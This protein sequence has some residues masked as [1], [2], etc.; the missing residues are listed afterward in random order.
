MADDDERHD[1]GAA[2]GHWV[3]AHEGGDELA[4][5]L[6]SLARD[7]EDEGDLDSTLNA[8][9]HAAVGTIPGA[10]HASISMVRGRRHLT[11]RAATSAT[12]ERVDAIQ[13]ETGEGPCLATLFEKRTERVVDTTDEPR[14]PRFGFRADEAGV[15]SLLAVQLYVKGD[16]LGA[17]NLMSGEPDA[18]DDDSEH[19]A[20]LLA[21][22]AAI[23]IVGAEKEDQLRDALSRRDV[24]G[25]AMGIIMERYGMTSERA[26]SVLARLSQNSNRKLHE[27]AAQIVQTRDLP[28]QAGTR[29]D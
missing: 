2:P 1:R 11:T 18:F 27:L 24:I 20:L 28:T 15:R 17:L 25:Q 3:H 21:T 13:Y 5:A 6:G 7:L 10:E 8:I 19:V 26:F 12:A 23:A 29:A 16:D 9:V 14:W 22:H 4:D